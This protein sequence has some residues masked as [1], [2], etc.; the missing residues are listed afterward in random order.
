M[1][2]ELSDL[3]PDL[4]LELNALISRLADPL[5]IVRSH[6]YYPGYRG[7]FSLKTVA[8]TLAPELDYGKLDGVAGGLEASAAYWYIASGEIKDSDKKSRLRRELL[9][10]CQLD[11][12][13]LMKVHLE[14][15]NLA[16]L[17]D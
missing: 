10:Y 1:I 4:A 13:A 17:R 6:T 5:T 15:R 9:N 12:E 14:L 16:G 8:P 7:S 2:E 3:F 11:T